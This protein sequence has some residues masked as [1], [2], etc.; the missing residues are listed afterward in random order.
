[1]ILI[2][3]VTDR[4]F[5]QTEELLTARVVEKAIAKLLAAEPRKGVRLWLFYFFV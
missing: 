3:D 5:S 1:M 2:L 4:E